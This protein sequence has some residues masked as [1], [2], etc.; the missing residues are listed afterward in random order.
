MLN[1]VFLFTGDN[2]Y[3]LRQ[4]LQRWRSSFVEKYGEDSLFVFNSEN[5]D[6]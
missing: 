6:N 1:S 2:V 5:W 4:E 3:T